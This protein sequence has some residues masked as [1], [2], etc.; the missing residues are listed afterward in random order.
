MSRVLLLIDDDVSSKN[1]TGDDPVKYLGLG[2]GNDIVFVSRL[3]ELND[4]GDIKS[5][6]RTP[7]ELKSSDLKLGLGDRVLVVGKKAWEVLSKV[8][9]NGLR[10]E[11]GYDASKLDRLG[12]NCG[13]FVKVL[14]RDKEYGM[15]QFDYEYF[16]SDD[17]VKLWDFRDFKQVVVHT[18]R[19]AV[20]FLEFF[21]EL[22][23]GTEYGYDFE[24]SGFSNVPDFKITGCAI[25]TENYG[26]FFSFTDIKNN[27]TNGE[28][29][30]FKKLFADFTVKKQ[31]RIWAYNLQF[32]QH[33]NL[34]EFGIDV[35]LCD[36]SVYN[37]I[38]GYQTKKYSLKW[39]AQRVLNSRM[40]S[41]SGIRSW[42]K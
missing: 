2:L 37:I 4:K 23:E 1:P 10:S 11:N 19:D 28:Y 18:Y 9:H 32:E 42:D 15:D 26:A 24:T 17:F 38:E 6:Y 7:S 22:P 3:V 40:K 21:T 13:A 33:V 14:W 39:T 8:Y 5:W 25:C 20:S 27:S 31:S 35:E 12:L 30:R 34:R 41:K 29:K 36:A 16:M